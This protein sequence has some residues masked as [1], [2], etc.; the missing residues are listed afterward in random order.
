MCN[1]LGMDGSFMNKFHNVYKDTDLYST[2]FSSIQYY[3]MYDEADDVDFSNEDYEIGITPLTI[4]EI[5]HSNKNTYLIKGTGFTKDTYF[6]INNK[7]VYNIEFVDEN[8]AIL[9]N[10]DEDLEV[11]DKIS[12]RIIGEKLGNILKESKQYEWSKITH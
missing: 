8:N 7:T 4:S 3:K 11:G 2:E 6:C 10:F 5:T 9:R 12:L 1:E